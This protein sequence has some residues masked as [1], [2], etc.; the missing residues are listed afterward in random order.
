MLTITMQEFVNA[1]HEGI[2]NEPV[3]LI[4]TFISEDQESVTILDENDNTYNS[5]KV[6][7][8]INALVDMFTY[9]NPINELVYIT[10]SAEGKLEARSGSYLFAVTPLLMKDSIE[11]TILAYNGRDEVEG[12]QLSLAEVVDFI[13]DLCGTMRVTKQ[14]ILEL[15]ID[16]VWTG[17][18]AEEGS[19]SVSYGGYDVDLWYT[20][21]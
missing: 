14:D 7:V 6:K 10:R 15:L 21:I 4:R 5:E 16:E 8:A 19:I 12:H 3:T 1:I 2:I 18:D 20:V 13:N 11:F 9:Q 17:N